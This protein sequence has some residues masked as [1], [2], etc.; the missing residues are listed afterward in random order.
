ME[1]KKKVRFT[2]RLS[3]ITFPK[4]SSR[5]NISYTIHPRVPFELLLLKLTNHSS[6]CAEDAGDMYAKTHS[7]SKR[8]GSEGSI[9][10]D[11]ANIGSSVSEGAS[12]RSAGSKWYLEECRVVPPWAMAISL[13]KSSESRNLHRVTWLGSP[14]PPERSLLFR[15]AMAFFVVFSGKSIST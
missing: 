14:R 5:P 7:K 4:E 6:N 3:T 8:V 1:T 15:I 2:F 13:E 12:R 9:K 10:E 11:D